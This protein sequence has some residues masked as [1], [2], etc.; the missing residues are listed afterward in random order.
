[1]I[2]M[3]S[4][5]SNRGM[6]V[7]IY[8]TPSFPEDTDTWWANA[9]RDY[10]WW[11]VW[12]DRY[13]NFLLHHADLAYR[14]GAHTLILGGDWLA[15]AMTGGTLPDGSS[16]GIP[17]DDENYWRNLIQE[18]RM[19][20]N[21]TIGW[22]ISDK[23]LVNNPPPFLDA[24]DLIYVEFSPRLTDTTSPTVEDMTFEA[25]RILD[26]TVLP[27]QTQTGKPVVLA[28]SA[29]SADGAA[30]GC[31]TLPGNDQC[32]DPAILSRPNADIPEIA[33]D[34]SEQADIYSA[35]FRSVN[36]RPWIS[37]VITSGYYPPAKLGDK[38]ISTHGKPVE[39]IMRY[40]FPAWTSPPQ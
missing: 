25:G 19:R 2:E 30:M 12:Y 36:D 18:I 15:P 39:D 34:L 10:P 38:S 29:L 16:S 31:L 8:P 24:V 40:W 33:I 17:A 22:A 23:Q 14:T 28:V 6:N 20:Y 27:L 37:G 21:G 5:T 7:A 11:V 3:V 9:P 35:I 26:E 1:M 13:M 4:Q 32:L